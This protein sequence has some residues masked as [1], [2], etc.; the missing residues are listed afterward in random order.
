MNRSQTSVAQRLG[1]AALWLGAIVGVLSLALAVIT[2]VAGVQPLI[3]RSASMEPS[4]DT[5]SLAI[6]TKVDARRVEVGDVVSATDREGRR[7]T[8][9]VAEIGLSG[10][11]VSLT[12]KGDSNEQPDAQPYVVDDVDRVVLDI[13]WLG[14]VA[15][16]AAGPWGMFLA[17]L[18]V[19]G[20]AAAFMR[21][22]AGRGAHVAGGAAVLAG[23]GVLSTQVVPP[24][25]TDAYFTDTS[26]FEAGTIVAHQ[27]QAFDWTASPCSGTL[28]Q[29]LT[30]S[31]LVKDARYKVV[32]DRL[33]GTTATRI[34]E[35]T[36]NVGTTTSTSLSVDELSNN[37]LL[38]LGTYSVI[39]SSKLKGSGTVEWLSEVKRELLYSIVNVAGLVKGVSC[40]SV[41]VGPAIAFTKPVAGDSYANE[42]AADTAV[43]AACD[44]LAAPCGTTTDT[45]GIR[46]V[47]YR[48]Q[49]VNVFGTQCWTPSGIAGFFYTGCGTWRDATTTP[50]LPTTGSAAVKW[51]VPLGNSDS[52][53]KQSGSYTLFIRV[54]DNASTPATTESSITFSRG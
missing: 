46:T 52:V 5:G 42:V 6:A 22:P 37:G 29:N 44:N 19:A 33:V 49:R 11:Q 2:V 40:G 17:G 39:G 23:L 47:Q 3:V 54:S 26:G 8:H 18:L 7:V 21:R 16:W 45:N 27:V 51:R 32:W 14:Y 30:L 15:S 12:L 25:S 43:K 28:A 36:P 53:F 4:I 20:L 38:A 41:N 35:V 10:S 31:Y 13:P 50:A 9:R 34:K 24:A 1:G 48:L